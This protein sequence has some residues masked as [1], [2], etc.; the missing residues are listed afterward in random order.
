MFIPP[1]DFDK[2]KMRH[3]ESL[4]EGVKKRKLVKDTKTIQFLTDPKRADVKNAE[5]KN[6]QRERKRMHRQSTIMPSTKFNPN[7]MDTLRSD[8]SIDTKYEDNMG[9][10]QFYPASEVKKKQPIIRKDIDY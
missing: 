2:F 10:L 4:L 8:H 6:A 5:N 3:F 9:N 7:P 1:R